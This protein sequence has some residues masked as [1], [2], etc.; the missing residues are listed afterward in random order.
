M[1]AAFADAAL[2]GVTVIAAAGD[3]G[4][5]DN[6]A[7]GAPHC[8]F[9]A[10]SPHVLGC[11]GTALHLGADGTVAG[12]VVWNDGGAGGATGGG[13]SATRSRCPTGRTAAGVPAARGWQ[14]RRARGAR[15]RGGRRSADRLPGARRRA[16]DGH[17]RHERGG[18]A[19]GRPGVPPR[20]TARPSARASSQPT[21]YA[22]ASPGAPADGF[23]DITVRQQRRV[24]GRARLGPVHRPRRPIWHG[25]VGSPARL[26]RH[27]ELRR[28]N[29]AR[30]SGSAR[31]APMT[32]CGSH[33]DSDRCCGRRS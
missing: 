23:R 16:V 17:R 2:L 25:T 24:L 15:R 29:A 4:S 28:R 6:E 11:G 26:M 10:S 12:E 9:P 5:T 1:D 21:L 7:Q 31:S 22:G 3:S 19:V 27:F 8:D 18:A 13:V 20:A 32:P 30:V 33:R 14:R